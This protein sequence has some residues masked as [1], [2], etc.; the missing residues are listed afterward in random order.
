MPGPG[1]E[2]GTVTAVWVLLSQG[3]CGI[4][5]EATGNAGMVLRK[6]W[7]GSGERNE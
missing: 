4:S 2:K 6:D 3:D 7:V 1:D 5:Q